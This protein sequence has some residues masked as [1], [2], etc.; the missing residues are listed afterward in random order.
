VRIERRAA[1]GGLLLAAVLLLAQ[2]ARAQQ[3]TEVLMPEQSSA[4][5][6]E[7]IAAAVGALGG[8]SYLNVSD[9]T[10]TGKVGQF[11][12]NGDLDGYEKF[13][14]YSKLPDKDRNENIPK[15]NLITVLN[16][17]EGWILDRG[18]VTDAAE[19][20]VANF[21]ED[22][23]KDID[24]VLRHRW[25]EPGVILRY[26]GPDV[27]DLKEAEWMELVDTDNRSIRIAFA[28]ATHLPVRKIVVTR[29]PGTRLRTEEVEYYSNYHVLGGVTTPLQI[30]REKNGLKIYQVFF[31]ECKYNTNTPDTLFSKASL[32]ERWQEVGKKF[33]KNE[34]KRAAHEKKEQEK[35]DAKDKTDNPS[36]P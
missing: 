24:N 3:Q 35:Q 11:G 31:E 4:K 8:D 27:V 6:K 20:T 22:L 23:R 16:G 25:K 14:D 36:S 12:H 2:G 15:R 32:D 10:C 34:A 33:R 13:I 29:D 18:G 1:I 7:L 5:A 9:V 21:Q 28:K 19:D 17:K 30:A 26:L